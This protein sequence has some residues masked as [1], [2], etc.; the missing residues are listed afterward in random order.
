[1]SVDPSLRASDADRERVAALL[2]DHYAAGR[3]D[4][5]ELSSRLDAVYA[6]RTTTELDRVLADLPRLPVPPAIRRAELAERRAE[7]RRHLVQQTGGAMAPF[8]I[9]TVIWAASGAQGAFW[10]AFTLIFPVIFLLRNGWALYGPAPDLEQVEA[11]L[12]RHGGGRHR[13]RVRHRRRHRDHR[14]SV[15]GGPRRP[16]PPGDGGQSR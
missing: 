11:E 10:P 5:D 12:R 8:A 7:L 6:S 15:G 16:L 14:R 4:D 9:C 13:D 1:M 2:R 3:I